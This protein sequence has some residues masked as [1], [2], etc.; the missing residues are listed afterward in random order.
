MDEYTPTIDETIRQAYV[1]PDGLFGHY[2]MG[3]RAAKYDAW[4]AKVVADA[5]AEAWDE[6]YWLGIN[7]HTGPGN[8]YRERNSVAATPNERGDN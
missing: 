5:K 1:R 6:G 8:P 3:A 7:G 2:G 4:L